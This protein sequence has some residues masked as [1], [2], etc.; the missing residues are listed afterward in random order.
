MLV[1]NIFQV[2][3]KIGNKVVVANVSNLQ[4]WGIVIKGEKKV[5]HQTT[6]KSI[7]NEIEKSE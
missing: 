4:Q 6:S 5:T 1:G 2:N 3:R 7:M